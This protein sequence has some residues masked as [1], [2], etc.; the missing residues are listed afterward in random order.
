[1]PPCRVRRRPCAH[2]DV[3][4]NRARTARCERNGP[5]ALWRALLAVLAGPRRRDE[6]ERGAW[7]FVGA[8]GTQWVCCGR[9]AATA[10]FARRGAQAMLPWDCF[11]HDGSL[12]CACVCVRVC[13]CACCAIPRARLRCERGFVHTCVRVSVCTCVSS[14][15]CTCLLHFAPNVHPRNSMRRSSLL[16]GWGHSAPSYKH[17]C[18]RA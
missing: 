16:F 7:V 2:A 3:T 5:L 10:G 9:K 17:T 11:T 4:S 13:V 12:C 8:P 18:V 1:M 15:A 14:R 6:R